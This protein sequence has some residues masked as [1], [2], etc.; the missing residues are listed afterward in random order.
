MTHALGPA[1]ARSLIQAFA[2]RRVVVVGDAKQFEAALRR[3]YPK[4]EV[5][6]A[7]ALKLDGPTLR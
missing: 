3:R 1:R 5:I 4:L 7:A 6:P 2:G